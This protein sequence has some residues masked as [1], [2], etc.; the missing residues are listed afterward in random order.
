M[1]LYLDTS[2]L[3]AALTNE[4][5]TERLQEWLE[6]QDPESMHIS[7]WVETEFSS[8]LSMKVRINAMTPEMRAVAQ[9]DFLALRSHS[10]TMNAVKPVHFVAAAKLCDNVTLALR[11]PD[12]LHLAVAM[13]IGARLCTLDIKLAEAAAIVGA[14]ILT[15]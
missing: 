15:P 6:A 8:A 3:V 11:A 9:S 4:A 14:S 2:I 1:N 5:A 12:A 13:Q 7:H 10:L